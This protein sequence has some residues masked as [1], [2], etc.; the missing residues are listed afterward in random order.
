MELNN[1]ELQQILG[2]KPSY[3]QGICFTLAHGGEL[4]LHTN[5][6]GDVLLDLTPE[7]GW[8]APIVEASTQVVAPRGQI[9]ILP[10]HVLLQLILGL[11]PL[12]VS[13]RLVIRHEFKTKKW[14]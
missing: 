4:Y 8:I 6:E 1:Q 5:S 14:G 9:W 7:A 11:N 12:L 10:Q 13:S 2:Q 3:G